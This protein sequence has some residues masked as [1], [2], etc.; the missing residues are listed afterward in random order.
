MKAEQALA[1]VELKFKD[2]RI[3]LKA[4]VDTGASRSLIS[5]R[6]A[7]YLGAFTPPREAL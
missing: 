5:K 1:E 3:K 7:D 6:L 2:G 4:S